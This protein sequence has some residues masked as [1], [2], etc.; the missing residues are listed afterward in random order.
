MLQAFE[1]ICFGLVV[2]GLMI[3]FIAGGFEHE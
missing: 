3:M 2:I 1:L